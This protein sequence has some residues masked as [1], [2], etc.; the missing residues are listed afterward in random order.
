LSLLRAAAILVAVRNLVP[1]ALV[2]AFVLLA[3]LSQER[4]SVTVDEYA[5][6][7]AACA[8]LRLGT[9]DLYGKNPPLV[10]YLLAAP[11]LLAGAVVPQ[12]DLPTL[13][14]GWDPWTYGDRFVGANAGPV[15]LGNYPAILRAARLAGVGL[16]VALLAVLYLWTRALFGAVAASIA[17]V[18]AA[19][20]PTLL[21]HAPLATVDAG[22][23][24]FLLAAVCACWHALRAPSLG[25]AA[26]GGGAVGLAVVAKFTALVLLPLLP[27]WWLLARRGG[28]A[29]GARPLRAAAVW[30]AAFLLVVHTAYQFH[31]PLAPLASFRLQS[32][33]ARTV[34][35]VLPAATPVPLPGAFVRGLDGQFLDLEQ[36]EMPNYL[37]GN[38]SRQG[39]WYYY[40]QAL[41][42]KT[43]LALW[44]LVAIALLSGLVRAPRPTPPLPPPGG[45]I[46][47]PSR[48]LGGWMVSSLAV[49][50]FAG[51]LLARLD[52]GIRYLLP[53]LPLLYLLLGAA[54][55]PAVRGLRGRVAVLL[56]LAAYAGTVVAAFPGYLPFFNVLA[57]GSEGGWRHLT[58]SNL[59]W[60]QDLGGLARYLEDRRFDAPV[61]L[62]YFGHLDPARYGID[63]RLPPDHPVPGLYAVSVNLL[64]GMPYIVVDHG[65]WVLFGDAL[66]RP[67]NRLAWL[68]GREPLARIGSSI[69]IYEVGAPL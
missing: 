5:H 3:V 22:G 35:G 44:G 2:L 46:D 24:L 20:C 10:R 47:A 4:E 57:G 51:A 65:A 27:L 53:A 38:W 23:A 6:L 61:Y 30:A 9:I 60:G 43:P 62:A 49:S 50:L 29:R 45:V 31:A 25:R 40:P 15:G 14:A 48:R 37:N 64:L 41:L 42:Q 16:G 1:I 21:A 52:I 11:A 28:L 8:A 54:L 19:F 18:L 26:L 59:D 13:G 7:P 63:Y 58:N 36:A 69:W 68:R 56:L 34:A 39:W 55:A 12:P 66:T 67:Q 33:L 17:L 32:G